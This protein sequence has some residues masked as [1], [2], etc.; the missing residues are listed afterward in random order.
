M[1]LYMKPPFT[2]QGME[3][4]NFESAKIVQVHAGILQDLQNYHRLVML[5]FQVSY[6]ATANFLQK[7]VNKLVFAQLQTFQWHISITVRKC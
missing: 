7:Q 2:T 1:M 6:G 5:L 3:H 4:C